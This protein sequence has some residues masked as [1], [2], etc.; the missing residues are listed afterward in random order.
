[1]SRTKIEIM[2][3]TQSATDRRAAL[4]PPRNARLPAA[5]RSRP[6]KTLG[7][8]VPDRELLEPLLQIAARVP[9]HGKL[10]PWRFVVLEH[11]P[12]SGWRA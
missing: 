7:L 8:P 1:V 12:A 9:D 11:P 2:P 3:D 6:P 5:R 10:E 4:L